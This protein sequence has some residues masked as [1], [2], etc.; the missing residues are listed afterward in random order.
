MQAPSRPD[1]P[2]IEQWHGFTPYT[3]GVARMEALLGEVLAGA[4][5]RVIFCEHEPVLTVGSSGNVA[6]IHADAGV[7]VVETGRGGKVTYHGPGQRVVYLVVDLGRWN[8]DVRAYVKWLQQWLIAAASELGVKAEAGDKDEIGVW[9]GDRKIAAIGVRVRKGVAY[10]G[11]ALN[12]ANDMGIYKRF[13]PCGITDKGVARLAD[14]GVDDIAVVDEAL[15]RTL[16]AMMP[17]HE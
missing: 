10:H 4:Q 3:D 15:I 13:V 6:D 2:I 16:L 9:V 11:I 17:E 1:L 5:E 14:M 12:V 8:K 7:P